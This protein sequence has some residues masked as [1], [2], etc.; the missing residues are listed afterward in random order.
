MDIEFYQLTSAG[1]REI[2]QDYM[3]HVLNKSYAL[4][5]V[6]DGLGGHYGGEKAS[7]NFCQGLL[8]CADTYGKRIERN[9][10]N[11]FNQWIEAG[12]H[13]MRNLFGDD[14]GSYQAYTT[15]AI[16][17]FDE[18][19]VLTGHCGDSRV[20]RISP[21]RVQWRTR[22]H[23]VPQQLFNEG[24]ITDQEM[25]KH[26]GQ[27]KLTRSINALNASPVE[28]NIFPAKKKGDTFLLCSDGFWGNIKEA[29]LLQLA[30][31]QSSKAELAKFA[32][33]SVLRANG[34]SDNVTVQWIRC[35]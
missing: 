31:P 34:N 7:R 32:Q 26:P 10:V 14:I 24:V 28:I 4:F 16:L 18:N 1:D 22:D 12:I 20:Y 29:E 3:A 6:A 15:C 2:N 8:K 23:S 5:V 33:L 35:L 17:Y 19:I 9:P 27:N 30:Q 21:D 13:E 11:V 25:G